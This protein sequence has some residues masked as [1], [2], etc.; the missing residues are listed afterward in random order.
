MKGLFI[1]KDSGI[2]DKTHIRL[3]TRKMV[4][5]WFRQAGLE[6]ILVR[7]QIKRTREKIFSFLTLGLMKDFFAS[8]IIV[9]GKKP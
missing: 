7:H 1:Y 4:L 6:T 9:I 3:T 5:S 2:F 8:Q